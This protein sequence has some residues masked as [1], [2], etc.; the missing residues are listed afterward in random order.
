MT[1][2]RVISRFYLD[3]PNGS[4]VALRLWSEVALLDLIFCPLSR[5]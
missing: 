5:G 1:V 4:L 2:N 3:Y